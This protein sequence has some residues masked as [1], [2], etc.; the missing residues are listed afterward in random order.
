LIQGTMYF[1]FS[2]H[3]HEFIV[4]LFVGSWKVDLTKPQTMKKIYSTAS[5]AQSIRV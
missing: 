5:F 4:I 3:I 2:T 1:S